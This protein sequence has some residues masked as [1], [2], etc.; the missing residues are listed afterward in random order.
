VREKVI[1][2]YLVKRVREH[3]GLCYKWVSPGNPGVPDRILIFD[4][5]LIVFVELKS[6]VGK[7]RFSQNIQQNLLL[8]RGCL[9]YNLNSKIGVDRLLEDL[10]ERSLI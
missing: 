7:L 1:E 3:E 5:N 8:N 9:V 6:P 4:G 10:K 2:E